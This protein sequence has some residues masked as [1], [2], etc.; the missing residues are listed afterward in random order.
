MYPSEDASWDE[1]MD[2][3]TEADQHLPRFPS[4][5]EESANKR[6]SKTVPLYQP[7]IQM[8]RL[9]RILAMILQNLYT[10]QGK[11]YCAK[12]GSD[13]IVGY[14]DTE[15]SKWRTALPPL[16]DISSVDKWSIDSVKHDVLLAMPGILLKRKP[17]ALN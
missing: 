6:K 4:L 13:A 10:P 12:H 14:L 5:D 15:L 16:L 11:I 8:V 9:S 1:V 17:T 3:M 7:L 2:I